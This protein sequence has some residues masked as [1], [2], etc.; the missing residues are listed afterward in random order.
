MLASALALFVI[1]VG[2]VTFK[3]WP[4]VG[5]ALLGR[6]GGDLA[7][8]SP[9]RPASVNRARPSTLNLVKSL[10]AGAGPVAPQ[11]GRG[12]ADR[13]GP[14]GNGD[15]S[16]PGDN[17]ST[18]GSRGPGPGTGEPQGAEQP[19]PGSSPSGNPVSQSLS[20]AGNAVQSETESL[21]NTLGGSSSPGPGGVV[22]GLGRTLNN[23]LQDLA[24][25]P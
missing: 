22:G 2:V 20:M 11:H 25:E 16:T 10:G 6:G 4:N 15:V 3:T 1:L 14:G 21:G 18:G 13:D 17:G 8:E 19:P 7:L 9:A 24:G 12:G 23:T 5:G